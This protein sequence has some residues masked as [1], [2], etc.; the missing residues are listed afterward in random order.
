MDYNK[1]W[2]EF[3]SQDGVKLFW[4]YEGPVDIHYYGSEIAIY[5]GTEFEGVEIVAV[6]PI[7][8]PHGELASTWQPRRYI[9]GAH[10][11]S[12]P[13]PDVQ[14]AR[15]IG[16]AARLVLVERVVPKRRRI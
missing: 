14:G 9:L 12:Q 3:F 2:E 7:M 13:Q 1:I 16:V 8:F 11:S 6:K 5:T 15:W 10:E 4:E